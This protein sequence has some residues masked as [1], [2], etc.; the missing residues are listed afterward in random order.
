MQWQVGDV[1]ITRVVELVVSGDN[2][3]VLPDAKNEKCLPLDWMQPHFMDEKGYLS[4]SVHGLI[5]DTGKHRIMVDTCIGN[6]KQLALPDWN[7]MQ[8]NFLGDLE[9]AGYAREAIDTVL[10]T[11]LHVDHVGWNTMLVDGEWVPTFPGARYLVAQAEWEHWD[12]NEDAIEIGPVLQQSVRPIVDAGLM[13]LVDCDHQVCPEVR[14]VPTPGHTPGHVS[15]LVESAGQQALITGDFIHHPV[16]LSH[17][18]WCSA[19][20]SDEQQGVRTRE[21]MFAEYVDS[22]VLIIGTHFPGPTAGHIRY[23]PEGANYWLDVGQQKQA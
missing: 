19:A 9:D 11:H 8:T 17:P 15:V 10:C 4:F 6:D 20:D 5:V 23:M 16:Q 18:E 2:E 12:A 7:N 14:L 21:N 13:Q 1:K 22:D 3:F